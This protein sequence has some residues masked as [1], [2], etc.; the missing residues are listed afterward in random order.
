MRWLLGKSQLG[1][2]MEKET[3]GPCVPHC[4]TDTQK[5][6]SSRGSL[7]NQIW[8][9]RKRTLEA[10]EVSHH[11]SSFLAVVAEQKEA[12]LFSVL[13]A[14][15][16]TIPNNLFI[17]EA[18][19]YSHFLTEKLKQNARLHPIWEFMSFMTILSL[20]SCFSIYLCRA[21]RDLFSLVCLCPCYKS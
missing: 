20:K 9:T 15:P 1:C 5:G 16:S 21:E 18:S 7:A 10:F 17:K 19:M 8:K 3:T 13:Q 2:C 11:S 4:H 6:F 12:C 14:C